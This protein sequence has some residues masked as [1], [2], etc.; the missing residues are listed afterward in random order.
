MQIIQTVL[1]YLFWGVLTLWLVAFIGDLIHDTLSLYQQKKL[2]SILSKINYDLFGFLSST[3]GLVTLIIFFL[4]STLLSLFIK[5]ILKKL[6]HPIALGISIFL[7]GVGVISYGFVQ[8]HVR[9]SS[10][11]HPLL[12]EFLMTFYERIGMG[13]IAIGVLILLINHVMHWRNLKQQK[14]QLI[15]QLGDTDN[16]FTLHAARLL[17]ASGWL[18]EKGLE[19]ANLSGANLEGVDLSNV[20]LKNV[21]FSGANLQNANLDYT[22]LRWANL[23]NVNLEGVSFFEVHHLSNMNLGGVDLHEK[24]FHYA[25][26]RN[27]HLNGANLEGAWFSFTNLKKANMRFVNLRD[28]GFDSSN[29]EMANLHD[30]DMRRSTFTLSYLIQANLENCNLQGA[31]LTD[32]SLIDA[33]LRGATLYDADLSNS[34][35]AGADL[36]QAKFNESTILPDKTNWTPETDMRRY[37]DPNHSD[38][39]QP[40]WQSWHSDKWEPTLRR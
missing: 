30:S 29:L 9:D 35:L 4:P 37:T 27:T 18:D 25:D 28:A 2:E 15:L 14:D 20:N 38:F 26:L 22:D 16:R 17:R 7:F 10:L 34:R 33:N 8:L 36:S 19:G 11:L 32:V 39:W 3:F 31:A 23:Y 40:E 1:I 21:D 24:Y 12:R 13:L 6:Q 5:W